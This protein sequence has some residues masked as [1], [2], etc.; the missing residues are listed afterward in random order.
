MAPRDPTTVSSMEGEHRPTVADLDGDNHWALLARK[1]WLKGSKSKKVKPE[2]IKSELWDALEAESFDFRSL[3]L[4]E[5]L[6]L[7]EKYLPLKELP[8]VSQR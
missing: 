7:L 6:H 8:R 2:V 1:H 3:L 4:L 5:N